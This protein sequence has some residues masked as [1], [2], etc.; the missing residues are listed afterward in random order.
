VS[1]NLVICTACSSSVNKLD[2][3]SGLRLTE[4][5]LNHMSVAVPTQLTKDQIP[6]SLEGSSQLVPSNDKERV[7]LELIKRN[8]IKEDTETVYYPRI[9][10]RFAATTGGG[11]EA[12]YDLQMSANSNVLTGYYFY[13]SQHNTIKGTI[14]PDGQVEVLVSFQI[15]RYGYSDSA[16]AKERAKYE[17]R[18]QAA[19]LH[20]IQ[21]G[22]GIPSLPETLNGTASGGRVA[23]TWY[24]YTPSPSLLAK[25]STIDGQPFISI[26]KCIVTNLTGL[27]LISETEA[28][29]D[30][31]WRVKLNELGDIIT[32]KSGNLAGAG[33]VLFAKKP[34]GSWFVDRVVL[35]AGRYVLSDIPD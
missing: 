4:A 23:V 10:G 15:P 22:W 24:T 14:D 13:G 3:S 17:E 27:R 2:E 35:N 12:G 8:F 28:Q 7:G 16:W 5:Y 11:Q 25:V 29:A 34:D 26:G 19:T 32:D 30:T 18:G 20:M 1:L 33:R 6:R 31:A 21:Q 9:S